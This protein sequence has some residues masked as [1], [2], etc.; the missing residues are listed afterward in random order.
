MSTRIVDNESECIGVSA[1]SIDLLAFRACWTLVIT[2]IQISCMPAES[3]YV[4]LTLKR[5][6]LQASQPRARFGTPTMLLRFLLNGIVQRRVHQK[7]LSPFLVI[8][9]KDAS[10]MPA[11]MVR[12]WSDLNRTRPDTVPFCAG[13]LSCS[14]SVRTLV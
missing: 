5:R 8:L 11:L 1:V 6:F 9:L 10:G 4:R 7:R 14:L 13:S 3:L 12:R 2:L